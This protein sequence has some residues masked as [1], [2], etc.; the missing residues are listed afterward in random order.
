MDNE[1]IFSYIITEENFYRTRGVPLSDLWEWKMFEHLKLSKLYKN[2]Q[3]ESGNKDGDKPIKNIVRPILNVAY[4]SEGF[5]VKDIQPFVNDSQYYWMSFLVKKY[6]NKWARKYSIDTFI[7]DMVES[8]VDYGGALIKNVNE[9]RPEV[10]PLETLAFCDQTDI[11]SGVIAIRHPYT[12]DQLLDMVK[13]NG[14]DEAAINDT[15]DQ[16]RQI[17][18]IPTTSLAGQ[19][20]M[21]PQKYIDVYELHGVMPTAW[22]DDNDDTSKNIGESHDYTRQIQIVTFANNTNRENKKGYTLFKAIEKKPV[23]KLVLRDKIYGRALGFGGVEELFEAQVWTTYNMIKM[24]DLLD[25]ASLLILKTD[26]PAFAEKNKTS[27]LETGEIALVG[28]GKMLDQVSITPQNMAAFE[29]AV[30]D[31]NEFAQVTGSANDAILGTAPAA[32]TPFALQQLL[33][34]QGKGLHDYRQGQLATF[35]GELYRDWVLP[36]FSKELKQGDKW[37]DDLNL[38][39]MQW[40]ASQVAENEVK[41]RAVAAFR[42]KSYITQADGEQIKQL[43]MADFA[44]S[45][46]KKFMEIFQ[47]ELRKIPIEVDVNVAGKQK[48]LSAMTDKLTNIFRQIIANPQVLQIPGIAKVFNQILESAGLDPADFSS[49]TTAQVASATATPAAPADATANAGT[50]STVPAGSAV[51]VPQ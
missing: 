44:K 31:W 34:Q 32:G 5:D 37:L 15:I 19:K 41:E 40:V 1:N 27:D 50:K 7:D 12:P 25:A 33:T 23:F 20:A 24:K 38:E 3:L 22:L 43:I 36:S 35:M 48:D 28:P 21:T 42:S 46:N 26:D 6:H 49:L 16:A 45:G 51:A 9:Q 2:S 17:K 11:L 47:N 14:W 4:R 10:V 18:N 8:Y 13:T 29:N 30:K 39:E